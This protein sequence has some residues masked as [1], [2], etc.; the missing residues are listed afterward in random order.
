[1]RGKQPFQAPIPF[2][3]D[4]LMVSAQIH[5]DFELGLLG[6]DRGLLCLDGLLIPRVGIPQS[7]NPAHRGGEGHMLWGRGVVLV[8]RCWLSCHWSVMHDTEVKVS[9]AWIDIP[10]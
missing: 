2:L 9:R 4:L 1:M 10:W 6:F 7:F 8:R 5:L 3:R